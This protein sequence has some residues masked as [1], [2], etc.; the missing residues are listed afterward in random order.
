MTHRHGAAL[1]L[2]LI[3]LAALMM[4]AL[5]FVASMSSGNT[6]SRTHSAGRDASLQVDGQI[7]RG[8]SLAGAAISHRYHEDGRDDSALWHDLL[9]NTIN[10]EPDDIID[11]STTPY[12]ANDSLQSNSL[13]EVRIASDEHHPGRDLTGSSALTITDA[14][15][16]IDVN[17]LDAAGWDALLKQVEIPDWDD[18]SVVDTHD[19]NADDDDKL[20]KPTYNN[21]EDDDDGNDYGELAEA[22]AT[23]RFRQTE[24][25]ITS[26]DQLLIAVD[27]YKQGALTTPDSNPPSVIG[28]IDTWNYYDKINFRKNLTAGELDRLRPYLTVHRRS[29]GRQQGRRDLGTVIQPRQKLIDP[30][31]GKQL[32]NEWNRKMWQPS[33]GVLDLRKEDEP[34][35]GLVL[36]SETND[37]ILSWGMSN[38]WSNHGPH[39]NWRSKTDISSDIP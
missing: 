8:I 37:G 26:L 2:S 36:H 23:V 13:G 33:R 21:L 31:T 24:G 10:A 28:D 16:K 25:R 19:N 4:I 22:L 38:N 15:T 27:H 3:I 39:R 17:D 30:S 9:A 6:A 20:G 11:P 29:S 12:W 32:R 14:S 18:N 5:P 1:V 34:P 7:K 35:S